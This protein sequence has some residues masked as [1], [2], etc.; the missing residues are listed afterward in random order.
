MPIGVNGPSS[1][2]TG[3]R[4]STTGHPV[5]LST[6]LYTAPAEP[7][8]LPRAR[9]LFPVYAPSS[10]F[11]CVLLLLPHS[12]PSPVD[13]PTTSFQLAR[14]APFRFSRIRLYSFVGRGKSNL[15]SRHELCAV[16]ARIERRLFHARRCERIW[17]TSPPPRAAVPRFRR[18]IP[19]LIRDRNSCK[20]SFNNPP[21]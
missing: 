20:V 16:Q 18:T 1:T 5:P 11:L 15:T 9:I 14:G 6:C 3:Y 12:T 19:R 21:P 17:K 10:R 13:D 7:S 8:P 4:L 2:S